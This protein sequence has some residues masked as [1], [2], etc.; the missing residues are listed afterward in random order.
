MKTNKPTV[1]V[2]FLLNCS[3]GDL[4]N[5]RLARMNAA[6]DLR[7]KLHEVLDSLLD[8]MNQA[9]LAAWFMEND[10]QALKHAIEHHESALDWAR[11]M[12]RGGEDVIPR[13]SSNPGEAHRTAAVTYQ[14]R[15]LAKGKC[16]ACPQP[17][18]HG[19]VQFCEKHLAINRA[20]T[21]TKKGLVYPG[22]RE[23]L[24]AGELP[25]STHGRQPGTMVS[26]ALNR[27]RKTRAVLAELGLPPESAAV[28]L[29]AAKE[30]LLKSLPTSKNEAMTQEQLF[31][32]ATVPSKTTGKKALKLLLEAGL[33]D[34]SG[35]GVKEDPFRHF[36]KE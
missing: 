1:P 36:A 20:H 17:L 25:E 24:Y 26:L 8:Q 7:K 12:V 5:F 3:D 21:R 13:I 29:G 10:R 15:N 18:A 6:A 30:A 28:S 9:D 22:S 33:I 34:R 2:N 11:R 27:E 31:L 32:K 16:R 14:K 19:S 4:A 23:Y 35:R